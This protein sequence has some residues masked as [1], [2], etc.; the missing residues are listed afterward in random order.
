MLVITLR[1][2]QFRARQFALAVIGTSL[3]FAM[4]L[5]LTG[6]AEGFRAEAEATVASVGAQS[7]VVPEGVGGPFTSIS[8]VPAEVVDAVAADPSV[9]EAAPILVSPATV[10]GVG[11]AADQVDNLNLIGYQPGGPGTPTVSTGRL[12]DAADEVVVD[13]RL[14]A[15]IGT[16]LGSGGTSLTVVGTTTG[17]TYFAGVPVGFLHIDAMRDLLFVG[18]PVA[19]AV[20]TRGV[21]ETVP[22]GYQ[23]LTNGEVFDDLMRPMANPT[24][25]ID[26]T[27]MFMWI[28]A[29]VIVGA[30]MYMSTLERVRDFAVLKAV[31]GRSM[32]L[33]V[34]LT[35]QS[36]LTA[37]LAAALAAALS[38]VMT[39][40]FALPIDITAGAY[41]ALPVVA[42]AVGAISS[43]AAARRALRVDPA[44]AFG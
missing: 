26:S 27:R 25:T 32:D 20:V 5:I 24:D 19:S 29:A 34:G 3:V 7:W 28:V 21:P 1:D 36:V 33:L 8:L 22:E 2:L 30:V 11:T 4:A 31:G 35:L 41:V 17:V 16:E 9:E 12:P 39:P 40:L 15:A 18:Q 23:L 10:R 6:M 37:L 42:V 44:L 13:E 38:V 43:A 14:G